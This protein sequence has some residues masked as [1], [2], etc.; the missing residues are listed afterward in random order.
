MKL[1]FLNF[2][3]DVRNFLKGGKVLGVDIGSVSIKA[4]ELSK[5][6][7]AFRLDNYGIMETRDYLDNPIFAIQ[8]GSLKISDKRAAG[9]LK[10]LLGEMKL[11]TKLA[12]FSLP[13][14][15]VFVT[16][17]DIPMLS[18]DETSKAVM[19]QARQIIP[20]PMSQVSID[21]TRIGEYENDRGLKYQKVLLV[22]IPNE[23]LDSYKN[24]ARM[25]GLR[26]VALELDSLAFIRAML[27]HDKQITLVADIGGEATTSFVAEGGFLKYSGNS[28]KGGLYLTQAL[29]RSLGLSAMRAEELKRKRGLLS[30]GGEFELSTLLL[31]FLDVI[32]EEVGKVRDLY[33]ENYGKKVEKVIFT[34]G[35][36][37]L[38]GLDKYFGESLG[39]PVVSPDLFAGVSYKAELQPAVKDL[40][41]SLPVAIGMAKKYFS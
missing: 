6:G 39:L 37:N 2:F 36:A 17:L 26:L 28:D 35:G 21:F 10:T 16:L 22:G 23:L 30:K 7:D 40:T 3:E 4:A 31:G 1:G 24:I 34:G 25:A 38:S 32:I 8:T 18:E 19:F 41:R 9:F 29:T 14:F 27:S 33:E 13:S 11:K 5:R 20:L 12:L 15:G